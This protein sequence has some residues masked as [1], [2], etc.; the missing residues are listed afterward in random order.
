VIISYS[1]RGFGF[2][3]VVV[4][5]SALGGALLGVGAADAASSSRR[6]GGDGKPS[7]GALWVGMIGGGIGGYMFM[8]WL[9]K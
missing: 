1:K 7:T 9:K 6:M 2:Y 3:G 5:W 8:N 4:P